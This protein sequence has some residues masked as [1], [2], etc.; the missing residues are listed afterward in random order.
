[1]FLVKLSFCYMECTFIPGM[2]GWKML[3]L[4]FNYSFSICWAAW[5]GSVLAITPTTCRAVYVQMGQSSRQGQMTDWYIFPSLF[6]ESCIYIIKGKLLEEVTYSDNPGACGG[7]VLPS[8]HLSSFATVSSILYLP[9]SLTPVT[10]TYNLFIQQDNI[11]YMY[12][13]SSK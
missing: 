5:V 1:M 4:S 8:R 13:V 10:I 12:L 7:A 3:L 11:T 6:S 9:F 2:G